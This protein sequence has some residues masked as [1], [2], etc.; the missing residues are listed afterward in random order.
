VITWSRLRNFFGNN[1]VNVPLLL[2]TVVVLVSSVQ[3]VFV[4]FSSTGDILT[5]PFGLPK[6]LESEHYRS[7]LFD[8]MIGLGRYL[9]NSVF[10]SV[11]SPLITLIL[12]IL[13]GYRFGRSCHEFKFRGWVFGL[14]LFALILPS[15]KFYIPQFTI[16]SRLGLF[17]SYWSLILIYGAIAPHVSTYL[18]STYFSQLPSKIFALRVLVAT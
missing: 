17:N 5:D 10:V 18:M 14:L 3:M 15:Q 8:Q 6:A 13:G 1:T 9:F 11:G 4:S 2:F 12:S 7:L 16:M